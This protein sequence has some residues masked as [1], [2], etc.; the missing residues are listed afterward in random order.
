MTHI[1]FRSALQVQVEISTSDLVYCV[2]VMTNLTIA[3]FKELPR[4]YSHKILPFKVA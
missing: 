4:S 2:P 3:S 1:T